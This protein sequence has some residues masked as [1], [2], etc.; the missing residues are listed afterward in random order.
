MLIL[1][2]VELIEKVLLGISLIMRSFR[3]NLMLHCCRIFSMLLVVGPKFF[4]R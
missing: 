3:N 4:G 2:V 1:D